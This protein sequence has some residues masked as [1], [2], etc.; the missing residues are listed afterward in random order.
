PAALPRYMERSLLPNATGTRPSPAR[1]GTP[2]GLP[3]A[4]RRPDAD[5]A[6]RRVRKLGLGRVPLTQG[7]MQRIPGR[8]RR[9]R[10]RRALQAQLG[11]DRPG[12][13]GAALP[14]SEPA[15]PGTTVHDE[16]RRSAA[17]E[18]APDGTYG[19]VPPPRRD[20]KD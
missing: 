17:Y 2:R 6:V 3:T 11:L 19:L 18:R 20:P 10:P 7:R 9:R 15:G 5:G 14:R 1:P 13:P 8:V 4:R 16:R 12:E